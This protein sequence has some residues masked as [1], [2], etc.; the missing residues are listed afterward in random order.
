MKVVKKI[1]SAFVS[2]ILTAAFLLA[3]YSIFTVIKANSK[4]EVPQV[5]GYSFMKV[6]TGS[7]EPTIPTNSLIVVKK[8]DPSD[9]KEGDII[10][11]YSSD[12]KIEGLPNTHRVIDVE[13]ESGK[14]VFTTKGDASEIPDKYKVSGDRV[15][16]RFIK[17]FQAEKLLKVLQSQYFFFFALLIPLC[18]VIFFE[19][20]HVKKVIA[21][22]KEDK[23]NAKDSKD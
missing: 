6:A 13:S 8:V 14:Y 12:P 9:V 16:G 15:V 18:V 19:F 1:F 22:K 17:S 3:G 5:L 23:T 4:G 10:C 7:M 11:F 2:L 20:L 21:Q